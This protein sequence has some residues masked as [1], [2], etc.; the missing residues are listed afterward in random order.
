MG[1]PMKKFLDSLIDEAEENVAQVQIVFVPGTGAAAGGLTRVE[2]Q[3]GMYELVTFT[4]PTGM[5][6]AQL[7]DEDLQ[8]V[9][10]FFEPDAVQR[11]MKEKEVETQLVTPA[12]AGG[13]VPGRM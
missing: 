5:N 9:S 8:A 12:G 11:V 1:A 4:A 6:P 3:D 7:R 13:I 10:M 2:G